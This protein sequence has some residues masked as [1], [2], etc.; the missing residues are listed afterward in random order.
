M[1]RSAD[2]VLVVRH[3]PTIESASVC[4]L[5]L[6]ELRAGQRD[7]P[8]LDEALDLLRGRAALEVEIKNVPGEAGYE[9]AGATVARDVVAALRRHAFVEAFVSSFDEECLRSVKEVDGGIATGLQVDADLEQA[10]EIVAGRH[11]FLLPEAG[12]LERAGRAFVDRA[13]ERDVRICAWTVDDAAEFQRI[14]ELGAD[15]VETN[16]PALGVRVRDSLATRR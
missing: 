10:L 14:F 6:G 1:R 3:D 2:G 5:T 8:T 11:A 12:A 15:A 9:P 4:D 7:I 16:D 13:H